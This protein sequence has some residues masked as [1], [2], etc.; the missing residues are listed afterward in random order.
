VSR[1]FVTPTARRRDDRAGDPLEGLVNLFELG[2]VL[3][4]AFLLVA[5]AALRTPGRGERPIELKPGERLQAL[6]ERQERSAAG[7]GTEVGR[8]YRLGDGRLVYVTPSP[9][10]TSTTPRP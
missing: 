4:L 6:P 10:S 7:R 8:V 9:T 3:A 1:R 5:L 2:I